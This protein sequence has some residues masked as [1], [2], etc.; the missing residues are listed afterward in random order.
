MSKI[1]VICRINRS[2]VIQ[3]ENFRKYYDLTAHNLRTGCQGKISSNGLDTDLDSG[4]ANSYVDK[5]NFYG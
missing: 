1:V 5:E 3:S 4:C 2:N